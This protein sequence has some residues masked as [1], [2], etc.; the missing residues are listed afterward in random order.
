M[1]GGEPDDELLRSILQR[2]RQDMEKERAANTIIN[3]IYGGGPS[4]GPMG[5]GGGMRGVMD[6]MNGA[7]GELADPGLFDYFVDIERQP[8]EGVEG[9]WKKKVHRYREPKKKMMAG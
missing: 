2:V 3:N 7:G 5:G 9:G 6:N 8:L 1:G 4:G